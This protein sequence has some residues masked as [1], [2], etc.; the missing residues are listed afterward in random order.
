MKKIL[1]LIKNNLIL[2]YGENNGLKNDFKKKI[3]KKN[4]EKILLDFNQDEI[5]KIKI[6]F[7]NEIFNISLFEK[8]KIFLLIM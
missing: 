7:Y 5:L 6:I 1:N 2:F 3:K 4:L 8:K